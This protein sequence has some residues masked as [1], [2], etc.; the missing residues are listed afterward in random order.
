MGLAVLATLIA[1]FYAEEDWR[2]RHAW[3]SCKREFEAKGEMLDWS[4][5]L[6]PPVPDE[7]NFFKAPKM[8]EWFTGRGTRSLSKKLVNANTFASI[9]S[10][11]SAKSYLS[12]SDP[13]AADFELIRE[14]LKRPCARMDGDYS[15]PFEIPIP[16]FIVTRAL[17]QVLAQRARCYLQLRLPE[18][19]LREVTLLNDSRKLLEGAPTGKPM[20]LVA[21]MI[22]LA[23]AQL[24]VNTI[25]DGL[26]SHSWRESQLLALEDQLK[27]IN[28]APFVVAG[29]RCERDAVCFTLIN[30]P[31]TELANQQLGVRGAP[32]NLWQKLK[33][34][35]FT[36]LTFAPRGWVDQNL[37]TQTELIQKLIDGYDLTNNLIIPS[38]ADKVAKE[39]SELNPWSPYAFL[40]AIFLPN[41][42]RATITFAYD[43]SQVN[44]AQIVCALERFRLAHG[45]YPEAL[46]NL[47]PQFI[48]KLPH[49]IIGGGPLHYHRTEN[50]GFLLYSVGWNGVDDGG[51]PAASYDDRKGDWV[52]QYPAR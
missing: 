28:L 46:D 18:E 38:Q 8:Q 6:P 16:N 32:T 13:F 49:D 11:V 27:Q 35:E 2:G 51:N 41:L 42:T 12:W 5:Y 14:A 44:E 29:F 40:E 45:N 50:D 4:A 20:T 48:E 34:P 9:T 15:Q 37:I 25:A 3:Q 33:I 24:Y 21:A 26:Q 31:P 39:I 36:F 30:T 47:V 7:Q 23:V 52:W 43:Q 17:A 10:D 22:N 1:V 19:A